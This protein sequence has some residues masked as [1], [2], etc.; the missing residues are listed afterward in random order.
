VIQ[1]SLSSFVIFGNPF[2]LIVRKTSEF[3]AGGCNMALYLYVFGRF[4]H[5]DLST[6]V[7]LG[8]GRL[9]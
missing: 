1:V 4:G 8:Q 3:G 7:V 9:T 2:S 5:W 6:D